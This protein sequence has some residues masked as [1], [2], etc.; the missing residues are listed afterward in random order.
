QTKPVLL[1]AGGK[2]KGFTFDPL[3]SL[4]KDKVKSAVRSAKWPRASG[5]HGTPR[6][7]PKS[8]LHSPTRLSARAVSPVQA[9]LSCSLPA[10]HRSTCS[11]VTPIAAINFANWCKR[12]H[13]EPA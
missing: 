5:A 12:S 13:N 6:S 10:H 1:S 8:Q 11:K 9:M 7:N 2:D 4:V 3:R